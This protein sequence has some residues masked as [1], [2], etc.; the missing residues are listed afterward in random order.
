MRRQFYVFLIRWAFNSVGLW[1]AV[2]VLGSDY[3]GESA[4]S[5]VGVFVVA[6]LVFS[7]VNAIIRPVITILALPAIIL[8]LGLFMVVV[9]GL[10]VYWSLAIAPG[11]SM[12]FGNSIL[13]GVK[14]SLINYIL[15][16]I[17]ITKGQKHDPKE[18]EDAI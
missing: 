14:L 17:L 4:L 11:L 5:G 13:A 16:S 6:G 18:D 2:R 1:V 7:L 9:N 10:M 3:S 12:T 15:D 8:T